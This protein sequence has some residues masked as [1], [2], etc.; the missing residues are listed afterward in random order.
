MID[1][2]VLA[3]LTPLQGRIYELIDESAD[4]GMR[5]R[6]LIAETKL[7]KGSIARVL[8]TLAERE[9]IEKIEGEVPRYYTMSPSDSTPRLSVSRTE[10]DGLK[11]ESDGLKTQQS[12]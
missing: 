8:I 12:L 5:V 2:A 7:G 4:F 6:D 9:I 1:T 3:T 11:K 10:S